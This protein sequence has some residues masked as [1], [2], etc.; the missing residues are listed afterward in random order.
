MKENRPHIVF[1]ASANIAMQRD[2]RRSNKFRAF[3]VAALQDLIVDER[4]AAREERAFA[5]RQT[6]V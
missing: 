1:S 4:E 2:S 6:I 5:P 3:C